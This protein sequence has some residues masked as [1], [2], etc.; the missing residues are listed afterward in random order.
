MGSDV[1]IVVGGKRIGYFRETDV[2]KGFVISFEGM[3]ELETLLALHPNK[4]VSIGEKKM[5]YSE[6]RDNVLSKVSSINMSNQYLNGRTM[7]EINV[8]YERK[9]DGAEKPDDIP[10]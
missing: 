4:Q 1:P 7:P 5:R 8:Q 9:D 2:G 10:F 6:F 3:G